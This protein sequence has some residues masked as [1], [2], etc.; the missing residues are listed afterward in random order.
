MGKKLNVVT[1]S[2]FLFSFPLKL[3]QTFINFIPL[4]KFALVVELLVAKSYYAKDCF[5]QNPHCLMKYH[6]SCQGSLDERRLESLLSS[7]R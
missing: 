7:L 3:A 1:L 5:H 2:E 6:L 4:Y